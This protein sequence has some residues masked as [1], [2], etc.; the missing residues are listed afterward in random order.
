VPESDPAARQVVRRDLDRDPI[1]GED[2]DAESAHVAAE[3]RKHVV[4]IGQL[5]PERCVREH[6][7]DRAFQLNRVFFRHP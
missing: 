4:A 7:G 6:L 3:R 2:A 1:A 5:H